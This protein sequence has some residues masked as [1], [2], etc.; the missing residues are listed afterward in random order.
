MTGKVR[1]LLNRD[2]RYFARLVIPKELRPFLDQK[3]ELRTP[4]G[5]DRRIALAKLPGAVSDLQHKIG[6]AERK[7]SAK[8][9]S[10]ANYRYPLTTP[11]MAALDYQRQIEFDADIRASD[12]RYARIPFDPA[13]AAPYREGFSGKLSDDELEALVGRRVEL[14][15][16][17]GNTAAVKGSPEWRQLAQALCIASYEA[18]A[19][20]AERDDGD[21]TGEPEH[22]LLAKVA[23]VVLKEPVSLKGLLDDYLKVLERGGQGKGARRNWIPPFEKLVAFLGHDDARRLT[24][25]NLLEWRDF[26]GETLAAKTVKDVYLAGVRAVLIWAADNGKIDGNP[27][28]GIKVKVPKAKRNREKGYTDTEALTILKLSRSYM[29]GPK[30]GPI[31]T[32]VKRWLPILC[33]FTGARVT[34]IA[35]LRK[36]DVRQEGETTVIR[37]RP[38]AGT[39]KTSDY[40]DVPLHEQ[41]IDQGF[42]D[43]V[44]AAKAGPL[45][46]DLL[47]N[48]YEGARRNANRFSAWLREQKVLPEGIQPNHAWRHRFKT[49]GMQSQFNPR[50]LDAIQ[51]HAARTAGDDYGDVTI[52]TKKVAIDKLPAYDL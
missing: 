31:M 33:A 21:F 39:V 2:G 6:L 25:E 22:P 18:M 19:R 42:L 26:L 46:H 45:F 48:P 51:G 11:Q 23:P 17:R 13:E 32:A 4:L 29:P 20:L 27:F 49:L 16:M 14:F 47:T 43:F 3:T 8:N 24:R 1:H 37:I 5:P 34:E 50:V 52:V 7:R 30:E 38:D 10:P 36:E 12:H 15:R 35:Q 44:K 9:V 28:T 41:V 40:R